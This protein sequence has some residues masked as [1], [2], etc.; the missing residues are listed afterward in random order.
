MPTRTGIASPVGDYQKL[1]GLD[2]YSASNSIKDLIRKGIVRSTE[3]GS[4]IY[5]IVEF[6]ASQ[7]IVP[8]ELKR[9]LPILQQQG[10]I[11]NKDV[12]RTLSVKP[13]T[14][15]RLLDRL[16]MEGWLAR[17]GERRGTHYVLGQRPL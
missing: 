8:D 6:A 13:K 7:P 1:T 2:I 4:R 14:A 3:K 15:T 17:T 11:Q 12:C 10:S 16:V 9:L 5:K